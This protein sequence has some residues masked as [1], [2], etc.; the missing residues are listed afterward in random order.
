MLNQAISFMFVTRVMYGWGYNKF[1][2]IL[3]FV[4][5][6]FTVLICSDLPNIT[7]VEKSYFSFF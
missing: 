5:E 1:L 6:I 7:T 4:L 3:L 2:D